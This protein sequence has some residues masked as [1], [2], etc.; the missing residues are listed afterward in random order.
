MDLVLLAGGRST[1]HDASLH[2]FTNVIA[3]VLRRPDLFTLAGVVYVDRDGGFHIIQE[4]PW[5]STAADL[6]RQRRSSAVGV[7]DALDWLA[8]SGH[9]CF[10]LLHGSEGEDGAWQGLA[11]VM[12]IT[13]SFGPVLPSALAMNKRLQS[14]VVP[15]LVPEL[16]L[17]RSWAVTKTTAA[18]SLRVIVRELAGKPVVVKPNQMGASLLTR[19]FTHYDESTLA[20]A[21]AEIFP[22]DRQALL[23]EYVAGPEYSCGVIERYDSP[24]ALPV[25]LIQTADGFFG[26]AQKHQHGTSRALI[27]CD[28]PRVRDIQRYSEQLFAELDLFGWCRFDYIAAP[29][30]IHFLEVNTIPGLMSGSLFP[31]ML[32]A[33]GLS[34]ADLIMI[35]ERASRRIGRREKRLAYDIQH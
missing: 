34:I 15:S 18:S 22:Y 6:V 29:G 14:L 7:S 30:G 35:T 23:Q 10:S 20:A 8:D 16:K 26:H 19:R 33:A 31:M 17:P 28:S 5:P 13:G 9:F 3:E 4:A 1:E 25:T 27:A 2:S 11:E 32:R 12:G 21:L 24:I